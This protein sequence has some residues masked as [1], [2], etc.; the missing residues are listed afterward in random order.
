MAA[1]ND[2]RVEAGI[3]GAELEASRGDGELFAI[4]QVSPEQPGARRN[5]DPV[6]A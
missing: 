2:R 4:Q 1:A 3:C 5:L 6:V